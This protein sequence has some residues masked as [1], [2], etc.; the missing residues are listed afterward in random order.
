MKY[1]ITRWY[2]E[3]WSAEV[4]ADSLEEAIESA[5]EW[6]EDEQKEIDR[7]EYFVEDADG[8]WIEA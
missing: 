5:E 8:D 4:E 7:E 6:Y 3:S 2:T 1:K